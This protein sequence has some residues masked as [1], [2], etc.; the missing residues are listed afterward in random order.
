M[1]KRKRITSLLTVLLTVA[2]LL[3]A[4]SS[5]PAD[6]SKKEP[7]NGDK[8]EVVTI[9]FLH[10]FNE[11]S[12]NWSGLI[13]EFE[14]EHPGIKVESMPLVDNVNAAD[15]LKKLDL[16]TASG[17]E[18]DVVAFHTSGEF[19]KRV[20][21]GMMEPIDEFLAKDGVNVAEEYT[22]DPKIDGKYYGLPA[23]NVVPMVLLNKEHLDAANLPIPTD[24]TWEEFAEYSK[25]LTQGEGAAKRYGTYLRDSYVHYVVRE[26]SLPDKNYLVSD[27]TYNGDNPIYRSTLELRNTLEN[28]DKSAVPLSE[29][30]SQK[31]DYRQQF[32]GGKV[33]MMV[34][35]SW[36]ISE[37]GNFTPDFT[38][39]WAPLPRNA[40]NK[41][42][43]IRPQGDIVGVAKKSA[44]K[45]AAYKF[46]RWFT[47]KGIDVQGTSLSSWKQA[48]T[49][50]S[51]DN[52]VAGTKR[53][54]AIDKES[55]IKSIEKSVPAKTIIPPVYIT[56]AEKAFIDE[57]QLYLLGTQD[58]DKTMANIKTKVEKIIE[59]NK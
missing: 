15:Y 48:N 55:L 12:G 42:V 16:M 20:K 13:E 6:P 10:W 45:E 25:K 58:I 43:Y 23:K 56:E 54:E 11:N 35:G 9:K 21:I 52:I 17:E 38:I 31:L 37:W 44:N 33:S 1:N 4:C 53:P 29:A 59:T 41:E 34:A 32:F 46:V 39:A 5:T 3:A 7:G 19:A 49:I 26:G 18:M 28:V 47:T 57:A 27:D 40:E 24:W 36:L 14:K 22:L 2:L 50:E 51:V 30:I 8:E